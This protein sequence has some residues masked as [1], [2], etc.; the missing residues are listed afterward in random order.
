MERE[1]SGELLKLDNFR[2]KNLPHICYLQLGTQVCYS[3]SNG[4]AIRES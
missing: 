2:L 3:K 1:N 4:R